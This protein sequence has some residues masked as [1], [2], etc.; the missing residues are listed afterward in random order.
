MMLQQ[1]PILRSWPCFKNTAAE[2]FTWLTTC[3]A[4]NT[5]IIPYV[6]HKFL[7]VDN[8]ITFCLGLLCGTAYWKLTIWILVSYRKMLILTTWHWSRYARFT[9][10]LTTLVVTKPMPPNYTFP[11]YVFVLDCKA[12]LLVF[13]WPQSDACVH[14]ARV[15]CKIK[16]KLLYSRSLNVK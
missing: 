5:Y 10:F 14:I 2:A 13:F 3:L 4:V 9:A 11:F 16:F 15:Y 8:Q 6:M 1:R 12:G 7:Q